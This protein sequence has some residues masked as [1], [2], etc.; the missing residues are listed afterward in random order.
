[1]ADTS[2][3]LVPL[4]T[5]RLESKDAFERLF[6]A[7][8]LWRLNRSEDAYVVVRREAAGENDD[9][10][11]LMVRERFGRWLITDNDAQPEDDTAEEPK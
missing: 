8:N 9:P 10:A 4:L 7:G 6:A 5:P 2:E 1:M 11:V 3:D